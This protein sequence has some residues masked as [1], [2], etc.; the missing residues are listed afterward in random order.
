M[1]SI[2]RLETPQLRVL[3]LLNRGDVATTLVKWLG[4]IRTV[5]RERG[6]CGDNAGGGRERDPRPPS[7]HSASPAA[8][9]SPACRHR[10]TPLRRP[11]RSHAASASPAAALA[12]RYRQRC[13]HD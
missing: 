13:M 1:A 6:S 5:R 4:R 12:R 3:R 7:L 8:A 9:R 11:P 2:S 10:S